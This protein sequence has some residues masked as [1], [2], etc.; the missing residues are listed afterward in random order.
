MNDPLHL[1]HDA[2]RDEIATAWF[3]R[4]R[5]GVM[6]AEEGARL[7][8]WLDADPANR[9]AYDA[10]ELTWRAADALRAEPEVLSLREEALKARFVPRRRLM[11]AAVAAAAVI[12][13]VLLSPLALGSVGA[14]RALHDQEFRTGVGQQATVKLPD[15]SVVTLNTDTVLRTRQAEGRRLLFLDKGQAYFKV[16]RDP[17]R[18]FVVAAGG[19]T[20]TA[21]GT[22]FDV[23]V[24]PREFKVTLVEG[25][26]R[27]EAPAS[28]VGLALAKA[29]AP[30]APGP[31]QATEMTAGSELAASDYRHWNVTTTDV[32]R[33]T[34][35][36]RGQ[37]IFE[38]ERLGDVVEELNR[39]S[40]KKIVVL[41]KAAADTPITAA[42][43]PG[44]I[45]GFVRAVRDYGFVEVVREGEKTVELRAAG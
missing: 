3:A 25:K 12:G 17:S 33:E 16:A 42:F 27:V 44:D 14:L 20:V 10:V 39:Y 2:D 15:G 37:L 1:E 8:T 31:V 13:G 30:V 21:L 38:R 28:V 29:G 19:R 23:R 18:P 26:V 5:S 7:E 22:A 6:T 35:W 24:S 9:A 11:A 43:R 45:D 36:L 41:D 40:T 32:E 4:R 34:S